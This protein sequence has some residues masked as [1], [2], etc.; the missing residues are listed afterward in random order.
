M[1]HRTRILLVVNSDWF[2]LSHRLPLAI[3]ARD[4]GVEVIVVAGDTGKSVEIVDR[5]FQFVRLPLSRSSTNPIT[6]AR[7]LF[8]LIKLYRRLRPDLVHHVTVKPIVYGSI[9]ARFLRDVAVVNA[10][11]G[12]AYT[13]SSDR[14]HARVLRPLVTALYRVALGDDGTRT[15]FQ[16]PDDRDDLIRLRVVR[17][18]QTVLIRGSGV[19]CSIF[20]PTPEPQ[21]TPVVMLP[22]RM[23]WEKG[24]RE[25]VEAASLLLTSGCNARFVLVGDSDPA[26][27]GS[28]TRAQL[29]SW[30]RNGLVEW[31]GHRTDMSKVLNSAHIVVLPAYREGLPKALLEAAAC[32]RPIVTTDVPGCREVVRPGVNGLLVPVREAQAL[33]RAIDTLLRSPALREKFGNAGREIVASEFAEEIVVKQTLALY[34]DLLRN[35][36]PRE[37]AQSA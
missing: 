28:I 2:F 27:P 34:R 3:A 33:A 29:E 16:N 14:A 6:D 19:D 18:E 10:V 7:T 31:W 21:G 11:S 13:F 17:P 1:N 36:W 15:I 22:A 24:V 37:P 35:R 30:T 9:A 26:N 25:F 12:L 5:G 4:A 23:L 8:F 20:V 32:A